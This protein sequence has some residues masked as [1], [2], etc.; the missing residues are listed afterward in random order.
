MSELI[1][2][3]DVSYRCLSLEL[4]KVPRSLGD[5]TGEL[6]NIRNRHS[7]PSF[8]SKAPFYLYPHRSFAYDLP[9]PS[10]SRRAISNHSC[11]H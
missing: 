3:M 4:N 5:M 2:A 7:Y 1:R 8:E 6:E 10:C 9:S 11:S